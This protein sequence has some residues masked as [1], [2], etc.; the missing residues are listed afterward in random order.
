MK[1][2][3]DCGQVK[4]DTEFYLHK[5]TGYRESYCFAC[6]Y[7]RYH[8]KPSPQDTRRYKE[9][10]HS[11]HPWYL[12]LCAIRQR[13]NYEKA[14]NYPWYGGRGIR[15]FM[16]LADVKALWERDGASEMEKPSIDRIDSDGHY[17]VSNCRFIEQSE[18]SRRM[19]AQ[20]RQR[21]A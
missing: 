10:Y 15:C 1:T 18:N 9:Q 4:E 7:Q 3:K 11:T 16:T 5:G 21:A 12:T 6:R 20:R 2:C 13:C 19:N 14:E 17:E 8:K